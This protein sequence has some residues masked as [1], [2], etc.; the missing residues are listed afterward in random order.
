MSDRMMELP[1]GVNS[2]NRRL[3][4]ALAILAVLYVLAVIVFIIV[5]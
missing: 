4:V 2:R 3:G 1:S 5:K